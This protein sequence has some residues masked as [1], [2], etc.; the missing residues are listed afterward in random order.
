MRINSGQRPL[1]AELVFKNP[2]KVFPTQRADKVVFSRAVFNSLS[3]LL[4]LLT[5]ERASWFASTPIVQSSRELATTRGEG[6]NAQSMDAVRTLLD[7][8]P[9]AANIEDN[10][11]RTPGQRT[12]PYDNPKAYVMLALARAGHPPNQP[13]TEP[14]HSALRQI[15]AEVPNSGASALIDAHVLRVRALLCTLRRLGIPSALNPSIVGKVY[16]SDFF[17]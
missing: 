4:F 6:R 15:A 8:Y 16:V 14:T 5:G 1:H 11:G 10:K 7:A 17:E 3:D 12:N 2:L 13:W 9:G